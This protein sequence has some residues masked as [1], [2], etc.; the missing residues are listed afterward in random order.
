MFMMV[1]D[2]SKEKEI[3]DAKNTEK[4]GEGHKTQ[5]PELPDH[6]VLYDFKMKV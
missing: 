2:N 3:S 6:P 5:A 1:H 4:M